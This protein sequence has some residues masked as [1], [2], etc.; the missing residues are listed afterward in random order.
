M[1]IIVTYDI[2]TDKKRN[3]L[4][5]ELLK[6]GIRTQYSFF[7]CDVN[8]KELNIIKKIVKKYSDADDFV[9]IY[10]TK[11]FKRIGKVEYLEIDDLVF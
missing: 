9:I 1:W 2:K 11:N 5:K 10:K 4:A 6:F 8:E 7:E 3:R